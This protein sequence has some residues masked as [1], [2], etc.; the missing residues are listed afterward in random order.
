MLRRAL[1]LALGA[2]TAEA[3]RVAIIGGGIS[4]SFA[5]KYLADYDSN[6]RGDG[7]N[8]RDCLLEEIVVYDVSPPPAG[9]SD[10]ETSNA[11]SDGL[12]STSDPRPPNYQGSRVASVTLQDGSVVELGASIIYEGN[13]LVVDTINGD[14][15]RL[16]KGKPMGTG[17]KDPAAD[18]KGKRAP[19]GLG[20]YHGDGEWLV[21]TSLFSQYPS[22]LQKV[23]TP[24]YFLYRYNFDYF[25]LRGAVKQAIRSFDD[26]YALLNDTQHE[27]TYF[28]APMDMWSAVGLGGLAGI[29]FHDFLDGLG[30][31]RDASLELE[32]G[33]DSSNGQSWW[34]WRSYFPGMGCM[35]SE[36]VTA[37]T[38]NTYNADL[39]SM[40]GLV[41]LVSYVPAGGELFSIEGGNYQL[42]ESALHQARKIYNASTCNASPERI[43]RHQK[44]ITAVVAG[45]SSMQLY[46]DEELLG[47][48]DVVILAAPLQQS[49]IRF[50]VESPMGMDGAIL[51]DMPL[52]GIH[53]NSDSSSPDAAT[54]ENGEHSF[55]P[56]LPSSATVPYTSVVT[57]LV[58]N[59]TLKATHFG[60]P[61][62]G[63]WP[64]SVLV[65]ERGKQMEDG[66]TTLTILSIEEGLM[67]TFSSETLS[68]EKRNMLF[69][70]DHT[71]EYVQVWGGGE[72][73]EYGGAT[74]NF[75]G[76]TNSESLPYLL[77]DGSKHWGKGEASGD[78]PALYYVNAI[79]S[80]VAA[81]EISALG[82]KSTAKLVARRL[83]MIGPQT[84]D[85]GHE[86]L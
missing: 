57:T 73:G 25:R 30:M 31:Y 78:G 66:L 79:E 9:F 42:M 58:S 71:V 84:G 10:A 81:I 49:R 27:V 7:G 83:G 16:K 22:F 50:M 77:Y 43:Q 76:G 63:P 28:Q 15:A 4:G 20:I 2:L 47:E 44:K 39:N 26:V 3:Y 85:E 17:K 80:A 62:D 33:N 38:L 37:M 82:A 54:N 64:R 65:S 56:S 18:G 13:R 48:F 24:L 45:E 86:E 40:N 46:A 41:G 75:G 1:F 68:V 5:A 35:R 29:P 53:A 69:G 23:L 6:H 59:A 11:E 8:A 60:L 19:K 72:G 12:R 32:S 21:D 52:G 70:P 55:A 61:A 34:D 51:H 14:P 74:P 67:K 36:L